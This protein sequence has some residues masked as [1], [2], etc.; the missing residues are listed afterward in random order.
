M[1]KKAN[2][3]PI[4]TLAGWRGFTYRQTWQWLITRSWC[5]DL[6]Q[7]IFDIPS[8]DAERILR[9]AGKRHLFPADL[10]P[11]CR[12]PDSPPLIDL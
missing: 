5:S 7:D 12:R 4:A 6:C 11:L 3:H 8:P 9:A 1:S 10:S 2:R